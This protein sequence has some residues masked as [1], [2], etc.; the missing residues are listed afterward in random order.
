MGGKVGSWEDSDG[1]HI[2]MGLHVFFFNYANLFALMKKVGAFGGGVERGVVGGRVPLG[3]LRGWGGRVG[4]PGPPQRLG[5]V[6]VRP[7]QLN[8]GLPT[9]SEPRPRGRGL[10]RGRRTGGHRLVVVGTRRTG[11]AGRVRQRGSQREPGR[12]GAGSLMGGWGRGTRPRRP[13]GGRQ[14]HRARRWRGGVALGLSDLPEQPFEL[15]EE[16]R[17]PLTS[18][19]MRG[20]AR[21]SDKTLNV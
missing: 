2:E 5:A 6:R 15:L 21:K 18:W 17:V 8:G 16:L 9:G 14:R 13:P 12:R 11:A 20:R 19:E 7:R 3:A 1:N 4:G 10:G